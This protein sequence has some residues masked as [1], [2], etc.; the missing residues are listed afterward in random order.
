MYE[1]HSCSQ[2]LAKTHQA[3]RRPSLHSEGPTSVSPQSTVFQGET[4]PISAGDGFSSAPQGSRTL[5]SQPGVLRIL[6][7]HP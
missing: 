2:V 4:R 6:P 1:S 7:D 3:E 5:P